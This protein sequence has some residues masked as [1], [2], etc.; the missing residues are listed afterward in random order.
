[1]AG[2]ERRDW[3]ETGRKKW[4][5]EQELRPRFAGGKKIG[6]EPGTKTLAEVRKTRAQ[7]GS[8]DAVGHIEA[9]L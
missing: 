8:Q 9:N 6:E 2:Q 4:N 1:M 5:E 3:A 7:L